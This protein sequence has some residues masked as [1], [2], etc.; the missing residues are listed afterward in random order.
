MDL[1]NVPEQYVHRIGRTARAGAGGVAISFCSVE[2]RPLLRDIERLIRRTLPAEGPP[3]PPAASPKPHRSAPRSATPA[4]RGGTHGPQR[5]ARY[6][7]PAGDGR[8][9][10]AGLPFMAAAR[11]A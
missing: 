5:P 6:G 2:E 1:P 3:A 4:A 8:H 11:R 9:A 10:L 7:S